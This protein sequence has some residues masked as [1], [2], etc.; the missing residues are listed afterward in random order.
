MRE[1]LGLALPLTA[2][3]TIDYAADVSDGLREVERVTLFRADVDRA[4]LLIAPDPAEVSA[5]RWADVVALKQD[6]VAHPERY[7]PWL[8]IY[9]L[10]WD[11]LGFAEITAAFTPSARS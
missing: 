10:R 4:T 2:A 9:L 7:A 6:A 5:T 3:A 8:R 1:E 11:E